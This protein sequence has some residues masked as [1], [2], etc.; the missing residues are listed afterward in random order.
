MVG[1]QHGRRDVQLQKKSITEIGARIKNEKRKKG[2]CDMSGW[3]QENKK[4]ER[5]RERQ[6]NKQKK[7]HAKQS[8]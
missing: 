2:T 6:T 1:D 7:Q 5:E 8:K 3:M 4:R